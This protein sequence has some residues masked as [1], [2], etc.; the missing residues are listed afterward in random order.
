MMNRVRIYI[1]QG[2][3]TKGRRSV[4]ELFLSMEGWKYLEIKD[5]SRTLDQNAY[6]WKIV[7]ILA[8]YHGYTTQEMHEALLD[9]YSWTVT[10][11]N[12]EGKPKQ[13]KFRTSEMGVK[14]MSRYME[15]VIQHA[16]EEGV[17]I[18]D[19]W[20]YYGTT[21]EEYINMKANKNTI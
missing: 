13:R 7:S 18:P 19:P 4:E 21:M 20:D 9:A 12:F 16:A 11:K 6:Y 14:Q 5:R 17:K 8:E 15:T 3:I 10:Y 1:S 2:K